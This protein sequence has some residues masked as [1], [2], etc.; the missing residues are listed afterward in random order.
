MGLSVPHSACQLAESRSIGTSDTF[1]LK[2]SNVA[3]SLLEKH[4]I[5]I[6]DWIKLYPRIFM[7][8]TQNEQIISLW[9]VNV[10]VIK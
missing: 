9:S 10:T 3:S 5:M 4:W 6:I 1:L 8:D 2:I 7:N